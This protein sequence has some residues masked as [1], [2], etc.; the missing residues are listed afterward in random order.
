MNDE[1]K[2][3]HELLVEN[4][5]TDFHLAYEREMNFYLAVKAGNLDKLKS[6]MVPLET[7]HMGKLSNDRIRNLK[8]HL[9]IAIALITRF[10]IEGGMSPEKAY[11]LSD[12][13]IQKLDGCKDI[14]SLNVLHKNCVFDFARKMKDIHNFLGMSKYI[15][16]A[17]EFITNHI[18][19]K[20]SIELISD[21]LGLN[22]SYLCELFKKETGMTIA[23]Y[24]LNEKI[25]TSKE[26]L[27][28]KNYD[29][30]AIAE[31]FCFSSTSHYINSFKKITGLT[32]GKYRSI[33]FRNYL[34]DR[35]S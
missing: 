24:I 15:V 32:P 11:S 26:L 1:K 30:A 23:K 14:E 29:C 2:L 28:N 20:L 34:Y 4:E 27:S 17:K 6:I 7:Q 10:C 5:N 8:Y 19:E 25:E 13:Y 22:K 31:H 9:R 12:N 35:D 21:F 16:K 33:K 3:I 18:H